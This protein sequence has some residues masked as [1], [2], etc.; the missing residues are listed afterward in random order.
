MG[1]IV[2]KAKAKYLIGIPA[3]R[4]VSKRGA[5]VYRQS[6]K[7]LRTCRSA[8]GLHNFAVVGSYAVADNTSC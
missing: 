5:A 2:P 3:A 8:A 1:S 6:H 4:G 7:P